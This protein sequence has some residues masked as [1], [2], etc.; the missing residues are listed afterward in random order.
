MNRLPESPAV[1]SRNCGLIDPPGRE[2]ARFAGLVEEDDVARGV[3]KSR[4]AP[5]PRLVA[6]RVLERNSGSCQPLDLSVEVV[7][8]EIDRR[9]RGDLLFG[10]G[11]DRQS[12][13]PRRFEAGVLV[14]R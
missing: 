11:L 7:A 13:A 4:L 5:H 2:A 9:R 8:F 12:R 10:I 6:G 14:L 1:E 3:A